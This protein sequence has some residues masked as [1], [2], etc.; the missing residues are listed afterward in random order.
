MKDKD[1]L[2]VDFQTL[3][4]KASSLFKTDVYEFWIKQL[5]GHPTSE[6]PITVYGVKDSIRVM[7]LGSGNNRHS[8]QN[9]ILYICEALFTYQNK[10][11][12]CDH[13]TEFHYYCINETGLVFKQS[14][15]GIIKPGT[16][17]LTE[18]KYR[19]ALHSELNVP[20]SEFYN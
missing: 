11:E 2:I 12:L 1:A 15:M 10:N 16:V 7:D 18:N 14:K 9:M 17:N 8:A 4:P 5:K 13:Q 3:L 6:I 20:D 19:I